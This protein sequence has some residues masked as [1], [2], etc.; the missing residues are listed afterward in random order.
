MT[1]DS[2]LGFKEKEHYYIISLHFLVII[3][4]MCNFDG[5]PPIMVY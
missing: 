5:Q 2:A 3:C 1:I 4:F